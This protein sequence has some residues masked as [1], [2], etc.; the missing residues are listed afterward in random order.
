[1]YYSSFKDPPQGW[2]K[3]TLMEPQEVFESLRLRLEFF[4]LAVILS[5]VTGIKFEFE[6]EM[7]GLILVIELAVRFN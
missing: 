3:V 2:L 4:I 5:K 6:A 7:M 1:M